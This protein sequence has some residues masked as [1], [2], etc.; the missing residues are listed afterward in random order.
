TATATTTITV[1][2]N[3]APVAV[4]NLNSTQLEVGDTLKGDASRSSDPDGHIVKYEWDLNGDGAWGEDGKTH[5]YSF[6]DPGDYDV[7]L[8][9]TDERGRTARATVA[10]TVTD[11]APEAEFS[12]PS[13]VGLGAAASFNGTGSDD[14]DG[15]VVD[16]KWDLDG[17]GV[18]ESSG[19]RPSFVYRA[20]G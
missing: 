10:T 13:A 14:V 17:D 15:D 20:P 3:K 5:S 19:S 1:R 9:V 7:G 16:W 2:T 8:R 6:G 18:Y 12:G 11:N 4:L